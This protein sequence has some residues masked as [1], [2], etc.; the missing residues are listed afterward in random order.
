MKILVVDDEPLLAMTA[1]DM[2]TDLGHTALEA[3][4]GKEALA[5]LREHGDIA[6]MITDHAMPEMTGVQLIAAALTLQPDLRVL[7]V[8]G[9]DSL[10]DASGLKVD[11]LP[12][13]YFENDLIAAIA[14]AMEGR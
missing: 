3:G 12:K 6:L 1:A 9:Y 5:L 13:P 8:S 11:R 10:P 14:R 2:L 7:L 4:S